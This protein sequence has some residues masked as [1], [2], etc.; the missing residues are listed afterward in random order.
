VIY[1]DIMGASWLAFIV[2]WVVSSLGVKKD[3]TRSSPAW[4]S[5]GVRLAIAAAVFLLLRVRPVRRLVHADFH[6]FHVTQPAIMAAGA[7]L[8]VV[9]VALAIWARTILGRNWSGRPATKVGHELVTAG[10]YRVVRH[11]IYSGM[12]TA[13]LGTF[14]VAG[15]PGLLVFIAF[16]AVVAYRIRVE[17]RLMAQLFGDRYLEYRKHTKALVPFIL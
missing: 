6:T 14:L 9:G 12:L 13:M 1:T 5:V 8:C 15:A 17:E 7:V 10:P 11:P 2:F 4:L 3:A 16:S